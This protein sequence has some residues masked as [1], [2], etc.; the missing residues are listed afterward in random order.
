MPTTR[1]A[2][3]RR[4][5]VSI[6][7]CTRAQQ[8][9]HIHRT[10]ENGGPRA[11]RPLLSAQALG[12]D[13]SR[14]HGLAPA[15]WSPAGSSATH[16]VRRDA[17]QSHCDAR[18]ASRG[19]RAASPAQV[20]GS[21]AL[22]GPAVSP[23]RAV[24][25]QAGTQSERRGRRPSTGD[26]LLAYAWRVPRW[27][28]TSS[29][30]S[31]PSAATSVHRCPRCRPRRSACEPLRLHRDREERDDQLP[32]DPELRN[33]ALRTTARGS[34]TTTPPAGGGSSQHDQRN[35]GAGVMLGNQ[36]TRVVGNCLTHNGEYGFQA[37]ESRHSVLC[38]T[39]R[40]QRTT[41]PTGSSSAPAAGAPGAA[42]SGTPA[43]CPIRY[44]CVHDNRGPGLWADTNNRRAPL[45]R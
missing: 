26:D 16:D 20:C 38:A 34:S 37:L 12:P 32:H 45:R 39:T 41:P 14:S 42:S 43:T 5:R 4:I 33:E 7:T 23:A 18:R 1:I 8:P 30:R 22:D 24:I 19:S 21:R 25:R 10:T 28:R 11:C 6:T 40:S 9:G 27:P 36:R 44:N 13:A 15:A 35:G 29:D 17:R 3:F 2:A 31:S